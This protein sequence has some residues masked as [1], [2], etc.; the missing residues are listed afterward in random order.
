M[1]LW[2]CTRPHLG[3]VLQGLRCVGLFKQLSFGIQGQRAPW[4]SISGY[5]AIP[6]PPRYRGSRTELAARILSHNRPQMASPKFLKIQN[7]LGQFQLPIFHPQGTG[8]CERG[9][10]DLKTSLNGTWKR[11]G[12]CTNNQTGILYG[13]ANKGR[14]KAYGAALVRESQQISACTEPMITEQIIHST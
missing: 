13:K 7:G 14:H 12:A 4:K 8:L 2:A 6:I 10:A 9:M 11:H 3:P 1:L 5:E